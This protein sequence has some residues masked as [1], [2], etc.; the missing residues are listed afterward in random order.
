M[1]KYNLQLAT[2]TNRFMEHTIGYQI[3]LPYKNKTIICYAV[4][5]HSYGSYS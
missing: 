5:M 1:H 4:C 3:H 2:W